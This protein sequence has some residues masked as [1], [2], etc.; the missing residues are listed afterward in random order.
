MIENVSYTM[1]LRCNPVLS[2]ILSINSINVPIPKLLPMLILFFSFLL[3]FSFEAPQHQQ[4]KKAATQCADAIHHCVPAGQ[5]A[6]ILAK[7]N[8]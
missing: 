5:T 7:S 8:E 3:F 6:D 4:L 2:N 1:L